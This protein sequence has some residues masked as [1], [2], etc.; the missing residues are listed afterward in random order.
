[1]VFDSIDWKGRYRAVP[2]SPAGGAVPQ[3]SRSNRRAGA[4]GLSSA[5]RSWYKNTTHVVM[6]YHKASPIELASV[7]KPRGSL[8]VDIDE[9][10]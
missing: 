3:G 7:W 9:S 6:Y 2:L 4:D 5:N 8:L 10:A 1:M